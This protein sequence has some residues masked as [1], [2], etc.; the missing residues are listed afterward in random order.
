[1]TRKSST[2]LKLPDIEFEPP[3]LRYS[4]SHTTAP[5]GPESMRTVQKI[6]S[7]RKSHLLP[8]SENST[9]SVPLAGSFL[10]SSVISLRGTS[11]IECFEFSSTVVYALC[12][13]WMN[14]TTVG[15][16]ML[17]FLDRS[18]NLQRGRSR[19]GT[20][21]TDTG[22]SGNLLLSEAQHDISNIHPICAPKP[23]GK[24]RSHGFTPF[25]I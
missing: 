5:Y 19:A 21:P 10:N 2:S 3:L 4:D 15:F 7:A 13:C 8:L 22:H 9:T 25:A 23:A 6:L 12:H 18:L 17:Y 20:C 14:R 1:M 16:L 24:Y 11:V